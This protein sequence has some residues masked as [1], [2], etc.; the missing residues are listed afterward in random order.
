ML[1][2]IEEKFNLLQKS[3]MFEDGTLSYD[4]I[5]DEL[6]NLCQLIEELHGYDESLWSIGEYTDC[7]LDSLIVGAFW[8]F[9]EW[10]DGQESKSY[11]I[12]C[13]LGSIFS[14]GMSTLDEDSPEFGVYECLEITAKKATK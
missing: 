12:L 7:T 8:H 14:P 3:I 6:I 13:A 11:A 5:Q 2:A 10:H 4:E 9:T 1:E